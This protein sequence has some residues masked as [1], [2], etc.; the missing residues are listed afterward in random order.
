MAWLAVC[1]MKFLECNAWS[2]DKRRRDCFDHEVADVPT[3]L[4][5]VPSRSQLMLLLSFTACTVRDT[6]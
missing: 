6:T 5:P 1:W 3:E 4:W 2:Y